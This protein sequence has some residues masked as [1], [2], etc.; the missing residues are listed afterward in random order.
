MDR[1]TH[2]ANHNKYVTKVNAD[3][4]ANDDGVGAGLKLLTA[5]KKWAENR[6]VY[7][8]AVGINSGTDLPQMD[9]F[10]HKLGFQ[11]TGGNYSLVL[12]GGK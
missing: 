10:L 9:S 6:G 4:L 11:Q 12:G 3:N 8:L 5:F 1:I 7:E 2:G